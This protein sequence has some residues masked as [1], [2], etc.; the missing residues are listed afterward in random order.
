MLIKTFYEFI[1]H[2]RLFISILVSYYEFEFSQYKFTIL[3]ITFGLS[4]Y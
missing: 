3:I 4:R 2:L 1:I